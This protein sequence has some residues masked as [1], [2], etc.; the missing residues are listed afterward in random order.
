MVGGR[1]LRTGGTWLALSANARLT[2]VTN[3]YCDSIDP[4]RRSR[5]E[6]PMAVL[7]LDDEDMIRPF[8]STLSSDAYNP[9]NLLYISTTQALA[10]H[11]DGAGPLRIT[12]L[13]PGLHVLTL[14]DVDQS[15]DPKTT[16]LRIELESAMRRSPSPHSLLAE[17]EALLAEHGD[18]ARC[19]LDATCVHG[20]GYGTVSATSFAIADGAVLYRYASGP[21]CCTP[22]EDHSYLFAG[23]G[24]ASSS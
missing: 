20:E 4:S 3:R 18:A 19:D 23:C 10:G 2:T 12:D 15:N 14:R 9:F 17:F 13:S 7:G 22:W 1:D 8:L 6:L 11:G 21:P 24:T 16:F 5:G